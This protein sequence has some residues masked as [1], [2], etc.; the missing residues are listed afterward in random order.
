[1]TQQKK[2]LFI[3]DAHVHDDNS[4]PFFQMLNNISKTPHDVIFLGDIFDLWI[5]LPNFESAVH[6]QF[7]EWCKKEKA[8]RTIGFIEGNHEF[9]VSKNY[10]ECFSWS[11]GVYNYKFTNHILLTHGDTVSSNIKYMTFRWFV[12]NSVIENLL[13]IVPFA[14]KI[15][16]FVKHTLETKG[17]RSTY[18]FPKKKVNAYA[19]NFFSNGITLILSGHYHQEY[20]YEKNG[21]KIYLLPPWGE[22]EKI[23]IL[24]S[25]DATSVDIIHWKKL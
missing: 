11:S 20:Q 5:A 18:K 16:R 17:R 14:S 8:N 10:N 23:A 6:F 22:T 19:D 9:F 25:L 4:E 7:L 13:K 15:T 12:R 2:T 1:M 21:S 24:S 3:T